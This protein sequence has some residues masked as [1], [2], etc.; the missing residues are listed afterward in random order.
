MFSELL[1]ILATLHGR[2]YLD[3]QPYIYLE[4][5]HCKSKC[6]FNSIIMMTEYSIFN[7]VSITFHKVVFNENYSSK[8]IP[9]KKS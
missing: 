9:R 3:D 5:L 4:N 7:F 1:N 8:K 6:L 2:T